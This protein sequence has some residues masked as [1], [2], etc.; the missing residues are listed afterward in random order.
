VSLKAESFAECFVELWVDTHLVC[1]GV[2]P[3]PPPPPPPP[4]K[5]PPPP[6][7]LYR[8]N[9]A[10]DRCERHNEGVERMECEHG[11]G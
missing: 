10:T 2:T 3:P 9:K 1:K 4:P 7:E 5:P 11:C 8:C 6:P